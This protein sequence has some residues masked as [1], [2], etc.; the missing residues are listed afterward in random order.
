MIFF[1]QILWKRIGIFHKMLHPFFQIA[2]LCATAGFL[3][4]ISSG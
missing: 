2:A 3:K 4:Q 1:G